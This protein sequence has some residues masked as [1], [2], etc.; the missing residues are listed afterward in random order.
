[1]SPLFSYLFEQKLIIWRVWMPK[2]GFL[3]SKK[4]GTGFQTKPGVEYTRFT[5]SWRNAN[6]TPLLHTWTHPLFAILYR[7]SHRRMPQRRSVDRNGHLK[8]F[9]DSKKS[10]CVKRQKYAQ[11]AHVNLCV[12]VSFEESSKHFCFSVHEP[13]LH[14]PQ[15]DI[16]YI[17][18]ISKHMALPLCQTKDVM[19]PQNHKQLAFIS[20]KPECV[21]NRGHQH[22]YTKKAPR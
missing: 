16:C 3:Q 1:M 20:N 19:C 5:V 9:G 4:E 6:S 7:H 8:F 21:Q 2:M 11:A 14:S 17:Q 22:Q 15:E 13:T 12:E 18:F 10:T